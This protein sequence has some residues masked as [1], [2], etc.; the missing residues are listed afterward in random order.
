MSVIRLIRHHLTNKPNLIYRFKGIQEDYKIFFKR[1]CFKHK[2]RIKRSHILK[3][4]KKKKIKK[5]N[6]SYSNS[7]TS[8]NGINLVL[9]K[10][11]YKHK[12]LL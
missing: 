12:L 10:K 5:K 3:I 2:F 4:G 7:P 9:V 6:H 11:V 8:T 1:I